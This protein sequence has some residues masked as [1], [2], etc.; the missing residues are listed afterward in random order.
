MLILL[1]PLLPPSSCR[2]FPHVV[3]L[4]CLF[5]DLVVI[6]SKSCSFFILTP[7][8]FVSFAFSFLASLNTVFGQGKVPNVAL[9]ILQSKRNLSSFLGR[10]LFSSAI[11][12]FV[13]LN[14]YF[15]VEHGEKGR[16]VHQF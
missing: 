5:Y 10:P 7:R 1:L 12:I 2:S 14:V 6:V 8:R 3:L 9:T 4:L 15:F 16:A 13:V 11:H